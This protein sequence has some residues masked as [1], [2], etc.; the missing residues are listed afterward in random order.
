MTTIPASTAPAPAM[1]RCNRCSQ[2]SPTLG[3]RPLSHSGQLGHTDPAPRPTMYDPDR[4][5]TK[6]AMAAADA[7]ENSLSSLC[8]EAVRVLYPHTRLTISKAK[9]VW[10]VA[11]CSVLRSGCSSVSTVA[12]PR[13]PAT[14]TRNT[15]TARIA[16]RELNLRWFHAAVTAVARTIIPV[17]L[18]T[19][20]CVYSIS[21]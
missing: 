10:A 20:L 18:A 5:T 17:L 19:S 11:R 6:V 1:R 16:T 21:V 9:M 15:V 4:M 2:P 13:A 7:H 3:V 14:P 12:P 8:A